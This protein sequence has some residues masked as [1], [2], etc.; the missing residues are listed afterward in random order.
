MGVSCAAIVGIQEFT[1]GVDADVSSDGATDAVTWCTQQS[2]APAFCADYDEGDLR[3]AFQAGA[4]VRV[5]APDVGEGGTA[6]LDTNEASSPP[7]CFTAAADAGSTDTGVAARFEGIASIA[8]LSGARLRFSM[9]I[10]SIGPA[11]TIVATIVFHQ[12]STMVA[13]AHLLL[14]DSGGTVGWSGS[15][16]HTTLPAAPGVWVS[17]ELVASVATGTVELRVNNV[18]I[19]THVAQVAIAQAERADIFLGVKQPSGY[20]QISF[21]NVVFEPYP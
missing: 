3:V 1:A 8:T 17:T 6:A 10:D 4:L 11:D 7:G 12:V 16:V 18:P 21:D 13:V 15:D 19:A 20:A 14:S 2:P 5:A 9:R